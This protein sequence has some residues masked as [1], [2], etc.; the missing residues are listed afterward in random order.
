MIFTPTIIA[1]LAR[2]A[3][4]VALVAALYFGWNAFTGHYVHIGEANI[5]VKWDKQK[6]V[7]T[8]AYN[9]QVADLQNTYEHQLESLSEKVAIQ[10]KGKQDADNQRDKAITDLHANTLRMR[11]FAC[12]PTPSNNQ[13]EASTD[14]SSTPTTYSIGIPLEIGEA[15]IRAKHE[16]VTLKDKFDLCVGILQDERK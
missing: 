2:I 11:H 6:A 9:K 15:A 5:Q 12:V 10:T 8:A 1:I 14:P 16:F 4:A 7:D 13:T 3:G